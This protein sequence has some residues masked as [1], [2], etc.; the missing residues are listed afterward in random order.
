M[1]PVHLSIIGLF[2]LLL[3]VI[4]VWLLIYRKLDKRDPSKHPAYRSH[5]WLVLAIATLVILLTLLVVLS[6]D[7]GN[8][9]DYQFWP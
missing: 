2:F 3:I 7:P 1:N 5:Q 9:E 4:G 6:S 8:P